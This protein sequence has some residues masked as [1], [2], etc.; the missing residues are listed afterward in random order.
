MQCTL[1]SRSFKQFSLEFEAVCKRAR[2]FQYLLQLACVASECK[3]VFEVIFHSFAPRFIRITGGS[4]H[5][6]LKI[7]RFAAQRSSISSINLMAL[8][9]KEIFSFSCCFSFVLMNYGAVWADSATNWAEINEICGISYADRI[10]G[11]TKAS[12]GQFPW[13]A[14]VGIVREYPDRPRGN[15]A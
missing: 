14:H 9:V 2:A 15:S 5:L 3:I 8:L 10:V 11:G 7:S 1:H 4:F 13:I 12:L 6:F